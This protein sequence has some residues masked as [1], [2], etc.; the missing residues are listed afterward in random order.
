MSSEAAAHMQTRQVCL[1]PVSVSSSVPSSVRRQVRFN[2]PAPLTEV[3]FSQQ[4]GNDLSLI[5]GFKT[6]R[7]L[8][9]C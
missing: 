7:K 1:R 2:P 6:G 3:S 4:Q 5:L 8:N 9:V